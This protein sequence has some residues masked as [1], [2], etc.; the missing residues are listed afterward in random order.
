MRFRFI[1][2]VLTLTAICLVSTRSEAQV[3]CH[4]YSVFKH[5]L[6]D[7]GLPGGCGGGKGCG[8]F[9]PPGCE[10]AD[11]PIDCWWEICMDSTNMTCLEPHCVPANPP[12]FPI[13]TATNG[14]YT[15]TFQ[16]WN[17]AG[18]GDIY[19]CGEV[20]GSMCWVCPMTILEQGAWFLQLRSQWQASPQGST[21]AGKR[22]IIC[23]Y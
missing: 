3:G 13:N 12:W 2:A 23:R 10:L 20:P 19:S 17:D 16:C 5:Y 6:N 8:H 7:P 1:A 11:P 18:N 15:G 9:R 22:S 21:Q 4:C 14:T